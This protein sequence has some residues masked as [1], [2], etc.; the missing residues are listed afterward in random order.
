MRKILLAALAAIFSFGIASAADGI[1]SLP[2][3]KKTLSA[4][5]VLPNTG[6][7]VVVKSIYDA[8]KS[9]DC[10]ATASFPDG[11]K[12]STFGKGDWS[13]KMRLKTD[14]SASLP[15]G[16]PNDASSTAFSL[17]V[18]DALESL[19]VYIE[20]SS[21]TRKVVLMN[22]ADYTSDTKE[23][24]LTGDK[25][26]GSNLGMIFTWDNVAPGNY[27]L[28]AKGYT[29][30]FIGMIYVPEN[31]LPAAPISWPESVYALK[32]RDSFTSPVL[33][34]TE[35]LPVT[36]ASSNT[37]LATVDANGVVTLVPN[38]LGETTI[39]ATFAGNDTYKETVASYTIK[40]ATN[41]AYEYKTTGCESTPTTYPCAVLYPAK[42]AMD[43]LF[44]DDT[45]VTIST[46]QTGKLNGSSYTNGGQAY[47]GQT[48]NNSL[49]VLV[50]AA[51]S[52]STP[53]GKQHKDCTSLIV[54]PK[55]NITLV[56]FGCRKVFIDNSYTVTEDDLDNNLLTMTRFF[57]IKPND[58][59][60]V[61]VMDQADYAAP[62]DQTVTLGNL[63]VAP[64]QTVSDP[65][66]LAYIGTTVDL[67]ADHTY[68]VYATNT[69]NLNGI[70]YNLRQGGTV[71]I[72]DV[73]AEDAPVEYF[74]LQGIRVENPSNGIFI[75][76]Q[77]NT[78]TKVLVK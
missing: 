26:G 75:R 44:L 7:A 30:G 72:E 41:V 6:T 76:R 24:A 27:I 29:A 56:I 71:E 52:A 57:S 46:A 77:G 15:E 39:S 19:T 43:G 17:E 13:A 51:P 23:A 28:Y 8:S 38:V 25:V 33:S 65:K 45:N 63:V 78:V 18:K 67:D 31:N 4:G 10:T 61:M 55:A 12:V 66:N 35:N 22:T 53:N 40:V 37:A 64:D 16:E 9:K 62:M 34:N 47:L 48:F 14:P 54:K 58:K 3:S 74:N 21:G 11:V 69:F 5:E 49:Q 32:I 73:V 42:P 36:Y 70:G 68:T 60:S 2:T 59:Y 20:A 1:V 50:D